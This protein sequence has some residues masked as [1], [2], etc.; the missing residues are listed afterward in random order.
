MA[1]RLLI[2]GILLLSLV[3][4]P[5]TAPAAAGTCR[6]VPATIEGEVAG[7]VTGTD[8]PDVIVT[9]GADRVLALGGDDLVCVTGLAPGDVRVEAGAG[10]D[11]VDARA[12]DNGAVEVVLGAGED[13][14]A[15]GRADERVYAG[16]VGVAAD[17]AR[18]VIR[19]R[20]GDDRVSS[21]SRDQDNADVIRTG[22]G[23]DTVRYL[24]V[25]GESGVL[26]PGVLSFDTLRVDLTSDDAVTT[27]VDTDA[28]TIVQNGVT[29]L[30]WNGY[31]AR[32]VLAGTPGS[33]SD[34][35]FEG[36]ELRELLM[37]LLRG[38][39]AFTA[40]MG[41]GWDNVKITRQD[42]HARGAVIALGGGIDRLS[43]TFGQ[44]ASAL[45]DLY[46]SLLQGRAEYEGYTPIPSAYVSGARI[47]TARAQRVTLVGNGKL[48]RLVALACRSTIR[49]MGGN[50]TMVGDSSS[51]RCA[52]HGAIMSGGL[53][54][55]RLWGTPA[56]DMLVG[57]DGFDRA[58]GG[59]GKDICR[60][61]IEHDCEFDRLD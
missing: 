40:H 22:S 12:T 45:N 51:F 6:G 18:D 19:T 26:D 43:L 58:R 39:P 17:D 34:V 35:H 49:G 54:D 20:S 7:T 38:S 36:N 37:L 24:G 23:H 42:N 59:P 57:G 28:Q 29:T 16:G 11:T 30:R 13:V 25:Q 53:G 15:G 33:G 56:D 21:G 41:G 44:Q 4:T 50:D 9:G 31:I 32:W 60:T 61:E 55:D 10:G 48:N 5:G 52:G 8:G 1:P 46:V 2:A 3:L 27:V 47:V 14:F